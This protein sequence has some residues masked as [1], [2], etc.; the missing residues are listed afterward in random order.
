MSEEI[1]PVQR[2]TDDKDLIACVLTHLSP[3]E[4][5]AA[6]GTAS[7]IKVAVVEVV[8]LSRLRAAVIAAK[9]H[10]CTLVK[11]PP[12][13]GPVEYLSN[14]EDAVKAA[15]EQAKQKANERRRGFGPF[16]DHIRT[17]AAMRRRLDE[18]EPRIQALEAQ[19]TSNIS[20]AEV[21]RLHHAA[22]ALEEE[23]FMG[24]MTMPGGMPGG[25][26]MPGV[27]N[28]LQ[29]M[30]LLQAMQMGGGPPGGGGGAQAG[31]SNAALATA[32]QGIPGLQGMNINVRDDP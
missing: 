15:E 8:V 28:P 1:G 9:G 26:G 13:M 10:K 19:Y 2:V 7:A 32:L 21:E 16:C 20:D 3:R 25:G 18:F 29:L 4:L 23:I 5:A 17:E 27:A 6:C 31:P 11:K 24:M 14:C 12:G 30:Q 22:M